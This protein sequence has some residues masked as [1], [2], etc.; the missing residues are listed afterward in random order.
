MQLT[1]VCEHEFVCTPFT[2]KTSV[3]E[4]ILQLEAERRVLL[5]A[6]L[7]KKYRD[8]AMQ[9]SDSIFDVIKATLCAFGLEC[10]SSRNHPYVHKSNEGPLVPRQ[11]HV[12]VFDVNC[13]AGSTQRNGRIP[14]LRYIMHDGWN[15]NLSD[16]KRLSLAQLLDRPAASSTTR[17]SYEGTRQ[18]LALH[19]QLPDRFTSGST[20]QA[21]PAASSSGRESMTAASE[22]R[23]LRAVAWW[24]DAACSRLVGAGLGEIQAVLFRVCCD[25]A[26]VA[27]GC[28]YYFGLMSTAIGDRRFHPELGY[29]MW[30]HRP[31][32]DT[33]HTTLPRCVGG[34]GGVYGG[35]TLDYPS[36]GVASSFA[37]YRLNERFA[38]GREFTQ[39][40]GRKS[41]WGHWDKW[42]ATPL[43]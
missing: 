7:L 4:K 10:D 3:E 22:V 21:R 20:E 11:A 12:C 41:K 26:S 35:L 19:V 1:V 15:N 8:L 13:S 38:A 39:L 28:K 17:R 25:Q 32:N 9:G 37:I 43:F 29:S 2:S 42:H 6:S 30:S 23:R 16:L 33:T 27:Q 31:L 40:F 24:V 18:R 36:G 5:D 14:G 34:E